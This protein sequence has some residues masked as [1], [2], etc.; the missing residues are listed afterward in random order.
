[1]GALTFYF[2]ICFG[3]RFHS[4]AASVAAIQTHKIGCFYLPGANLTTWDKLCLFVRAHDRI[5]SLAEATTRP[6]VFHLTPTNKIVQIELP[7]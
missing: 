2:D 1:M 5:V 6:F 4:E 7:K 3:R